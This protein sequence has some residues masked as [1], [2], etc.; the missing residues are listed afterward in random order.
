MIVKV[1]D[2]EID[3]HT[4]WTFK[5]VYLGGYDCVSNSYDIYDSEDKLVL[6]IDFTAFGVY[7]KDEECLDA[8]AVA[9]FICEASVSAKT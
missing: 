7:G 9:K 1:E 5:Y 3:I 8:R 6:S 4:P 2:Q